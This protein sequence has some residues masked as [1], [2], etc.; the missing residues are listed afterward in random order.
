M[1]VRHFWLL[2]VLTGLVL[3]GQPDAQAYRDSSCD[4][5]VRSKVGFELYR[6]YL[7]VV[8]GSVGSLKGLT[9]LIDTGAS[10]SVLDPRIAAKLHLATE[11]RDIA[12]LEGTVQ[13]QSA[14]APSI[15][16]GHLQTLNL[17]V[18]IRD[19]SFLQNALPIRI[20]GILGL[21]VLG[22]TT[23]VID[24]PSREIRFGSS[25][26]I[27]DS[28]CNSIPFQMKQGLAVVEATVN[29]TPVHL[30]L[31]TGA[32]SLILFQEIPNPAS[33]SIATLQQ[34]SKAI[35]DFDRKHVQSIDLKLGETN[36]GHEAAFVVLN[37]KD[38]G[39]DFDGLISPAALGITRVAFDP[40]QGKL[41]LTRNP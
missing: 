9:F 40:S 28:A 32:S 3:A 1:R 10:P 34:A 18:L 7:I 6:D 39:H 35:G 13:G 24:Y 27:P 16:L 22:Q 31:D 25:P 26:A 8:R 29:H 23:F 41:T 36:F 11:S 37:P 20:D 12:I 15:Q 30:L 21:D 33:G 4:Q 2:F 5:P 17:P 14:I 38:A 19:L